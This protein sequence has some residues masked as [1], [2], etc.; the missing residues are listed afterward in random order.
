MNWEES[1]TVDLVPKEV[2][3]A[4]IKGT[5]ERRREPEAVPPRLS[6]EEQAFFRSFEEQMERQG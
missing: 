3:N 5:S 2:L 4:I 1:H 6:S